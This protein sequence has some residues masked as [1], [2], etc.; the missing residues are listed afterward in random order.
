MLPGGFDEPAD[1]AIERGT[2]AV[3]LVRALSIRG[4]VTM[5]VLGPSPRYAVRELQYLDIYP[6]S[7]PNQT[8]K[9][10]EFLSILSRAEDYQRSHG[11]FKEPG[12]P[13]GVPQRLPGPAREQPTTRAD[14]PA[15]DRADAR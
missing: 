6:V 4:G 9:G 15:D 14:S 10:S 5:S 2:L 1:H 13:T 3:A 7:S 11:I 8:F 12:V